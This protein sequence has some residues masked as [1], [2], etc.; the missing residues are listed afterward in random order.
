MLKASEKQLAIKTLNEMRAAHGLPAVIY[1]SSGDVYTRQAA[2]LGVVNQALTHTPTAQARC[3]TNDGLIGAQRSNLY[4]R[5]DIGETT[6]STQSA[7]AS[8]LIDDGIASLGHRRW[9]LSP[10]FGSTSYGRV[11]GYPIDEIRHFTGIAF[12]VTG[13]DPGSPAGSRAADRGFVAYP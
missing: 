5:W 4:L 1:D 10:F 12:S 7:L 8:L 9:M 6:V 2:L 11:D 3:F 13:G